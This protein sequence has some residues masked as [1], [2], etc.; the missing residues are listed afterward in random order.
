[1]VSGVSVA[2]TQEADRQ[3]IREVARKVVA[4][5]IENGLSA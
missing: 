3:L 5:S 2:A 1:V 4:D